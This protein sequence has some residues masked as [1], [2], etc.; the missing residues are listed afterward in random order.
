MNVCII[1]AGSIGALKPNE[2]D[3]RFSENVLTHAHALYH[4]RK[5]KKIN[6][7][8][9]VEKNVKKL[10]SAKKKWKCQ[11]YSGVIEIPFPM[12]IIVISVPTELHKN[13]FDDIFNL[14]TFPK[15]IICEKPFTDNY[16]QALNIHKKCIEKDIKL[17]IN[18]TR[19]FCPQIQSLKK[20]LEKEKINSCNIIYVRGLKRDACHAIDLCNYFFGDF[21]QGKILGSIQNS[22]NDYNF[23]DLTVPVWMEFERC[24]NVFLTPANGINY[25]IFEIDIL[26]DNGRYSIIDHSKKI[27]IFKK[28]K[29]KIYGSFNTMTYESIED[30]SVEIENALLILHGNCINYLKEKKENYDLFCTG[31]DGLKT[32]KILSNLLGE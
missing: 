27:K 21:K 1:G 3:S 22:F 8:C 15:I 30:I 13:I 4:F 18:Y 31:L 32:Q 17:V 11:G 6:D 9:I 5:S 28:E 26:T 23:E 29:E 7:F 14:K 2:Y 12:D 10:N 20:R 25:S 19:R 24:R 16:D